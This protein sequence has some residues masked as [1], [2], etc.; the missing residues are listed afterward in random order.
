MALT[1]EKTNLKGANIALNS[2]GLI[3]FKPKPELAVVG[4]A[5]KPS[6]W[7]YTG[8]KETFFTPECFDLDLVLS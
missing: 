6:A 1:P 7:P 3:S 2:A 5:G 8:I 4:P